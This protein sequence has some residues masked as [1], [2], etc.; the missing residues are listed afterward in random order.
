[1]VNSK[2]PN[3]LIKNPTL[4]P[5]IQDSSQYVG[6]SPDSLILLSRTSSRA[7]KRVY[8]RERLVVLQGALLGV[9]LLLLPQGTL[10]LRLYLH[11]P[12]EKVRR[13]VWVPTPRRLLPQG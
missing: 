9:S 13:R 12:Q 11:L 5:G 1:M 2:N 8:S 4:R 3:K 10:L 7:G 6:E